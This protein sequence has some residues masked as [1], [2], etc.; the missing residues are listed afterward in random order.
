MR[1]F[2]ILVQFQDC[3]E[4]TNRIR[5][6]SYHWNESK[7]YMSEDNNNNISCGIFAHR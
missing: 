1:I 7:D 2:N 6:R 4:L 3:H 5:D